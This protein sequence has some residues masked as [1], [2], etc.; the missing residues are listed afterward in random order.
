MASRVARVITALAAGAVL[1]AGCGED[2]R[3]KAE[4][5]G[6]KLGGSVATLVACSDWTP[7]S[8]PRKLATIADIRNQVNRDDTGI[9]AP[10]LS[11]TE[12]MQLF[13]QACKPAYARSF[14]LYVIYA[15]AAGFAP[16]LRESE[17]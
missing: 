16:L 4:P 7:G 2:E 5:L 9:D 10:P 11:D 3:P 15:R 6:E 17:K 12:A 1:A 14:R 8:R 13:D